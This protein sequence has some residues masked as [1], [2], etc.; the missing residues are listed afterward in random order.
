[1][2][3]SKSCITNMEYNMKKLIILL[4][5][6]AICLVSCSKENSGK[7]EKDSPA[8]IFAKELAEKNSYLD[9]DSN[10]VLI[11]TNTV[12]TTSGDVITV[13]YDNFGNK[14]DQVKAMNGPRLKSM[15]E[16]IAEDI[17]IKKILG[18][19]ADDFGIS[20]TEKDVDSILQIQY[21]LTGGKENFYKTLEENGMK[22]EKVKEEMF[23][24]IKIKKYIDETVGKNIVIT[25][26]EAEKV[27]NEY[28]KVTVRH[29]LL[30]TEDKSK[31]E[32]RKI[33]KQIQEI[34]KQA[35]E[36]KDFA[37]LAKEYTEDPGSKENGGL[38]KNFK[39][40]T[41]V[42]PFEEAAFS[43]KVGE[44]SDIIETVYGYHILKVLGRSSLDDVKKELK[45]RKIR[46]EYQKQIV[47]IKKE[48]EFKKM[49][50]GK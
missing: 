40:G 15:I 42:K 16:G 37:E 38:Y 17:T 31:S 24:G 43:V 47:E 21:D 14:A 5:V 30:M 32:K 25:D 49:E 44:I 50:F 39:R 10:K 33:R 27:Y 11:S 9:P 35:L 45:Q 1:M 26:E 28:E 22:I 20:V 34:H 19:R 46:I 13:I 36:E 4:M 2:L 23:I 18:K 12:K 8:Y 3:E 6:M 29:I 41:M 7:L 48:V